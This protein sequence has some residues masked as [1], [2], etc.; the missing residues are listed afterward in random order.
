MPSHCS[1]SIRA[2]NRCGTVNSRT[3]SSYEDDGNVAELYTDLGAYSDG[4][5]TLDWIRGQDGSLLSLQRTPTP[6]GYDHESQN[7]AARATFDVGSSAVEAIAGYSSTEWR[8]STDLDNGPFQIM[9]TRFTESYEQT[10]LELRYRSDPAK[11]IDFLASPEPV[12]VS[13]PLEEVI[14]QG[15]R[16]GL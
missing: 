8:L 11:A 3:C 2:S 9:D 15:R 10:S 7:V 5:D 16:R 6:S 12:E 4:S 14:E 1:D 13:T